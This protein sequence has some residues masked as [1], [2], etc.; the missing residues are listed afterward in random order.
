MSIEDLF[1]VGDGGSPSAGCPKCKKSD[2]DVLSNQWGIL[3]ICR[4]C[5][6]EWSGGSVGA[7]QPDFS[8][9][10]NRSLVPP[11]GVPAP[12]DDLPSSNYAESGFRNPFKN[13]SGDD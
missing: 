10:D 4:K 13:Y 9:P 8:D 11:L 3:R 6:N 7:G 2:W 5:G 12:D 1:G